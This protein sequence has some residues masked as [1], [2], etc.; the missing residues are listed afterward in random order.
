MA[1]V[2]FLDQLFR[3]RAIDCFGFLQVLE[4]LSCEGAGVFDVGEALFV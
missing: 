2:R 3:F 4:I 1:H